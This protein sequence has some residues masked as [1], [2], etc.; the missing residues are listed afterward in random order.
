LFEV[1]CTRLGDLPPVTLK[2]SNVPISDVVR[3]VAEYTGLRV[4]WN[5]RGAVL[6]CER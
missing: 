4:E 5:D 6:K 3:Y 2:L 1:Q